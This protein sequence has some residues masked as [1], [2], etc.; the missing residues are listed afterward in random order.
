M[1]V[2]F[3]FDNYMKELF[4]PD[5]GTYSLFYGSSYM[6][7]E[8]AIEFDNQSSYSNISITENSFNFA[9]VFQPKS[10]LNVD[11]DMDSNQSDDVYLMLDGYVSSSQL[12]YMANYDE[13]TTEEAI[14]L[15]ATIADAEQMDMD[16]DE[17][18]EDKFNQLVDQAYQDIKIQDLNMDFINMS[19]IP[20]AA[21]VSICN[22]VPF[23]T[24]SVMQSATIIKTEQL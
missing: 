16:E 6:I 4:L 2:Y 5:I 7:Q 11:Y 15:M 23:V 21:H 12:D 9:E 1:A 8:N 3:I 10:I 14:E 18:E 13:L 17:L 19:F 24:L 20:S 22:F